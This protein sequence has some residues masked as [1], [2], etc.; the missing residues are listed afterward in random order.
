MMALGLRECPWIDEAI[1]LRQRLMYEIALKRGVGSCKRRR[2]L[3]VGDKQQKTQRSEQY[4]SNKLIT[5][6]VLIVSMR[7]RLLALDVG[8][9]RITIEHSCEADNI[10][11][12]IFHIKLPSVSSVC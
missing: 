5:L 7:I 3:S 4:L 6:D 12:F 11:R 8:V 9:S 1:D 2:Q 10:H